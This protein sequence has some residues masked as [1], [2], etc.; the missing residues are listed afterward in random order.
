MLFSVLLREVE[1]SFWTGFEALASSV[2]AKCAV[3]G[4]AREVEVVG[5]LAKDVGVK[6]RS[7]SSMT[8]S[9]AIATCGVEE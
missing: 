2:V 7:R 3:G 6:N 4:S 8:P 9:C 1:K 5:M